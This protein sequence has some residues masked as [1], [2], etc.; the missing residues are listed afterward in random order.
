MGRGS[1]AQSC[2]NRA[3]LGTPIPV[4]VG[5]AILPSF[6]APETAHDQ[7]QKIKEKLIAIR[8]E[9][10]RIQ[11]RRLGQSQNFVVWQVTTLR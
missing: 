9:R 6:V 10:A 4:S 1:I 3:R 7:M 11:L 5:T 8:D 2:A